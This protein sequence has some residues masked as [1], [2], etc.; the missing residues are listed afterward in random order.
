ML[1]LLPW[2]VS[3]LPPHPLLI[4][5]SLR[6]LPLHPRM[7]P[8][9]RL[10]L[11]LLR[12]HWCRLPLHLLLCPWSRLPLHPLLC[13]W[14]CLPLLHC[15]RLCRGLVPHRLCPSCYPLRHPPLG[16]CRCLP[17]R[18]RIDPACLTILPCPCLVKRNLCCLRQRTLSS[19]VIR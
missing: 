3:S 4:I 6:R 8:I 10:P 5:C 1:V 19:L 2:V 14:R 11:H 13:P 7:G 9:C 17:R 18:H 12:V 15:L 16:L